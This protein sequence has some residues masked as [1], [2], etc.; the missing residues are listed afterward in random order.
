MR[1]LRVALLLFPCVA[2]ADTQTFTVTGVWQAPAGVT[3]VDV[4]CWGGGASPADYGRGQGGGGGGAYSKSTGL[5][6]TPLSNYTVTIGTGGTAAGLDGGNSWFSTTG[7]LFAE[8]GK[9][10]VIQVGGS[11]GLAANGIG[12]TKYSGGAGGT[13][14]TGLTNCGGGGG[15]SAGTGSDGTAGGNANASVSGGTGGAAPV[16]GGNGSDGTCCDYAL[17]GSAPGGAVGGRAASC[18]PMNSESAGAN[19]KCILT[20]GGAGGGGAT[21]MCR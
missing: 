3:S 17:A 5:S 1:L 19:G 18:S 16:G 8:G 20:W 14:G 2:L 4:E 7:T 9:T 11:G 6:V 21:A 15:S 13:G 12:A 10:G